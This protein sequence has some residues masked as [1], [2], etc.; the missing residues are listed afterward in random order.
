MRSNNEIWERF[1]DGLGN[2][3][4]VHYFV[5]LIITLQGRITARKYVNSDK[6]LTFT[7]IGRRTLGRIVSK[8][9]RTTAA[10]VTAKLNIHLEGLFT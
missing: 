7:E 10:Q 5:G 4:G 1:C 2:N 9:H 3:I 8:Y 6:K